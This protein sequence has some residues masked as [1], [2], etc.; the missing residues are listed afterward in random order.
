MSFII[1]KTQAKQVT[2]YKIFNAGFSNVN[3]S[4]L[5]FLH[6]ETPKIMAIIANAG[7][8]EPFII[9]FFLFF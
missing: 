9:S 4:K 3:V 5:N 7:L 6:V 2:K 8:M 1:K